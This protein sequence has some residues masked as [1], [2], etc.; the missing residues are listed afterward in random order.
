MRF[1]I[2]TVVLQE[3]VNRAVKGASQNKLITLTT[4]MAIQLKDKKLTLITT[5]ASNTLY[6]MQ[7][8]VEGDDFYC[9]LQVEQFSKLVSRL[10]CE[11]TTLE[12]DDNILLVKGNGTYK[13][14]LPLDENGDAIQYPD[15]VAEMG[16]SGDRKEIGL[17]VVKTILNTNKAALAVTMEQPEYTGYWVGDK[18]VATDTEKICGLNTK[19]FDTPAL[20]SAET[21]DLLGVMTEEKIEVYEQEDILEFVTK[22]CIV[23][24]HKM[25]GLEDYAI[26]AITGLLEEEFQSKCKISKNDLLALLDRI[27]LFVGTYDNKAITLTFT[28]KG[29]DV[30]SKQSNGVETITYMESKGFKPYTCQIAIDVLI[31]QVKANSADSIEL[32]YGNEQSIKIVDGNVT[33]VIALLEDNTDENA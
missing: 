9:V 14:E 8:G 10:T 13:I 17:S 30:S 2:K 21:M 20:I 22:D 25:E 16:I 26:D 12:L 31:Q 33:Q 11:N 23:F 19:F 6:V 7:D 18:V 3:L 27:A 5:D 4:L 32:Q 29:I 1:S 28:E 24:G 15:P